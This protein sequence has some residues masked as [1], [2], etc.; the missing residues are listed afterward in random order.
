MAKAGFL[1][2]VA[3]V[4][5]GASGELAIQSHLLQVQLWVETLLFDIEVVGIPIFV[6]SPFV[7]GIVLPLIRG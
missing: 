1:L 6:L 4:L 2:G 3:L 7:F 5:V